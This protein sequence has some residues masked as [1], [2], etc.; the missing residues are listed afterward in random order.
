MTQAITMNQAEAA[1]EPV[2]VWVTTAD[3]SKLLA[4]QPGVNFGSDTGTATTIDVDASTTY[5][6]MD[7]FGASFT[8]SSAWLVNTKLNAA[9]RSTLMGNLFDPNAGIGLSMVRQ[10][11]GASDFTVNSADYTYDDTCCDVNDFTISHD[12]ADTI[13]VLK[14]AKTLNPDLKII[15]SPWSPPAW[16]KTN[17]SLNGGTLKPDMYGPYTDYFVKYAQAYAAEGLPIYAVTLQNEPHNEAGYPSMRM[18]PADQAKAAKLLGPKFASNGIGTKIIVWDHNWDEPNFPTDVLNDP[19][20][21]QYI[22]GSAF[23]C[24]AGDVNA[25]TTVHNAHPDRDLWFTECSGGDWASDFGANLKWNTQQLIIGATRNWAK[26]VTMWNMALDQNHGPTNGGCSN[27]RGVVTVDTNNGN[28]AYNV[29]YYVL[30]HAAKFV[31]PGAKRI[32][33]TTYGNDIET[34]A[35]QNPNGSIALVALNANSAQRTFKV[36]SAGQAFTYTLPAGAVATF[37]WQPGAGP[38][39]TPTVT[40]TASPTP[41]PGIKENVYYK[42]T[43]R[44]SGKALDVTDVSTSNGAAIQ[45]WDYAGGN[46]QK[47]RFVN[48]GGGYYKIVSKHS[49]KALDVRSASTS[50]GA[51]VQQWDYTSGTNQQ[52]QVID[53]GAGA[54]RIVARHS[55]KALD[56]TSASTSN[57][58]AIQQWD[59]TAGTNQQFILTEIEPVP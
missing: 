15:G 6:T 58:A 49:G 50:N 11:I 9:Q 3:Q 32:A 22:A 21:K 51:T 18:E 30:G 37:T 46:N 53:A 12:R 8:D 24:Y 29:E 1:A 40:P 5:Q 36:R 52:W 57:G 59:Y 33:S 16:M 7:G 10:P 34:A 43:A 28:V 42:V 4:A 55:G 48:V 19:A 13:P 17:N 45:Q 35:F 38:S 27:C 25:Q 26:S 20:A 54:Y 47:W 41:Q 44:H 31:K 39:P 23:H 14:Q 2:S 56:V